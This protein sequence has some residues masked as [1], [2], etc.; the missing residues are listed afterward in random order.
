MSWSQRTSEFRH[1]E[2]Y[3]VICHEAPALVRTFRLISC[4]WLL[5]FTLGSDSVVASVSATS[6]LSPPATVWYIPLARA[7]QDWGW[8]FSKANEVVWSELVEVS[9][10][11][12]PSAYLVRVKVAGFSRTSKYFFCNSS[13]R[14]RI[15]AGIL[16]HNVYSPTGL[17]SLK[18][19]EVSLRSLNRVL[20]RLS[21]SRCLMKY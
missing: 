15:S 17:L 11:D 16:S 9:L 20:A 13:M 2:V 7:V 14:R 5:Y 21:Q 8:S 6:L 10:A 4:P 3:L 12:S 19:S 18:R 1:S